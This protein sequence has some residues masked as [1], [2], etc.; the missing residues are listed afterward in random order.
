MPEQV[1][2]SIDAVFTN[3]FVFSQYLPTVHIS[4]RELRAKHFQS[5]IV[6]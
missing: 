6:L 4:G 1:N 3:V 2:I 5:F